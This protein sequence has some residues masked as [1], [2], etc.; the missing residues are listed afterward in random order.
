MG[1]PSQGKNI[2]NE[3]VTACEKP[4]PLTRITRSWRI[5][6]TRSGLKTPSSQSIEEPLSRF[7]KPQSLPLHLQM[8]CNRNSN[9]ARLGSHQYNR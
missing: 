8:S 7:D 6:E 1:M 3:V 9:L 4:H 2:V 5:G